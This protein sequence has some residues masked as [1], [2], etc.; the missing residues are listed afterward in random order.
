MYFK[1]SSS[2]KETNKKPIQHI[3][4]IA[5]QESEYKIYEKNFNFHSVSVELSP[6]KYCDLFGPRLRKIRSVKESPEGNNMVSRDLEAHMTENLVV[7]T[8]RRDTSEDT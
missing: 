2:W 6:L 5:I 7:L 1:L 8:Q 3:S 4:S